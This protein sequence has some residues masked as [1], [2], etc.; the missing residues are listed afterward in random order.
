M[1]PWTRLEERREIYLRAHE[2]VHVGDD[3]FASLVG[4]HAGARQA[5]IAVILRDVIAQ[6]CDI[7]SHTIDPDERCVVLNELMGSATLIGWLVHGSYGFSYDPLFFQVEHEL[8]KRL[9]ITVALPYRK[10][11]A[12]RLFTQSDD[13]A[14][15]PAKTFG[16]WTIGTTFELESQISRLHSQ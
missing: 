10:L 8:G 12:M 2:H 1:W 11:M 9:K 5:A 14:P 3:E 6:H 7:S 13:L 15:A 16:E 4:F